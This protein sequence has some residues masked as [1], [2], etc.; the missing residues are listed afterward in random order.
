MVLVDPADLRPT[1]LYQTVRQAGGT[2][3]Q[4]FGPMVAK[5]EG[6]YRW[7]VAPDATA[8][9]TLAPL[10]RRSHGTLAAGLEYG[11]PHANGSESTF[12]LEG[13]AVLSVDKATRLALTP[14]Q[15]D[16]LVGWRFGRN[17]EAS[18]EI[19]VLAIADLERRGEYLVS[20]SYQQRLGETWTVRFGVR[21]FQAKEAAPLEARGLQLIR[22]GDHVRLS[23]TRHF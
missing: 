10:P 3:Q 13:Q 16:L 17:D 7:F 11:V 14:F 23:L 22:N 5:L 1:L 12:L 2:Y 19:V 21:L 18:K 20:A 15:R 4:V 9:A 6:A 8:T